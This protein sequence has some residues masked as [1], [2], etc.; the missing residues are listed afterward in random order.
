MLNIQQLSN[1]G[2]SINEFTLI[3]NKIKYVLKDG[4]YKHNMKFKI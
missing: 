4:F 2:I 3:K 1:N